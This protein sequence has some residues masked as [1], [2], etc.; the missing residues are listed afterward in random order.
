MAVP[1]IRLK[2][3]DA[4]W[5]KSNF[6]N[7]GSVAMCK[8]IFKDQTSP[9]GDIPFFKIGTFGLKPDAYITREL[10]NEYKSKY[11]FPSKGDILI[12]AAGTIGRTIVYSGDD[13][14]F[15]DSNIVW[16]NHNDQLNNAFLK[17]LYSIVNWASLEGATIKRLYNSNILQTEIVIPEYTEQEAISNYFQSLDSL[18]EATD[19]KIATL[20]QTKQASLQSMFPQEGETKPR[21]RFKGFTDEWKKVEIGKYGDTYSGLSGKSKDDF[22]KGNAKYITFLN[23]LTNAQINTYILESVDVKTGERQNAVQKGDILFNTSSETPE[24]VGLCSVLLEDIPNVYL[25]SFCFGFR[26]NNPAINSE[27]LVYLMRGH[28]GRSIMKVL[29]QGA[30]RYNLSKKRLCETLVPIPTNIDEQ[31]QIAEYFSNLDKQI[32]IQEQRLEKLKQI[33]SACLKNMFV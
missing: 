11:S 26:P 13:A 17:Y 10:Y 4:D 21:V 9:I 5:E 24:E 8:R 12:S 25:N 22:G 16:L 14:Y 27:F 32:S 31:K 20:K 6:G 2:G 23:V 1:K 18:I 33:K 3:F 29:A 28:I 19:K 15:Q 30:T 7:F